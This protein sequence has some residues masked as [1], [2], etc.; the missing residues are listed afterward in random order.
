[1]LSRNPP[2]PRYSPS[3]SSLLRPSSSPPFFLQ[4]Q[5]KSLTP[6]HRVS[7]GPSSPLLKIAKLGKNTLNS[8]TSWLGSHTRLPPSPFFSGAARSRSH[9]RPPPPSP[10]ADRP[11]TSV[12][13]RRRRLLPRGRGA[14]PLLLL[15]AA[16]AEKEEEAAGKEEERRRK[17]RIVVF[18]S[19]VFSLSLF[20]VPTY[21]ART[22]IRGSHIYKHAEAPLLLLLLASWRRPRGLNSAVETALASA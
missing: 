8:A 17:K 9:A 19:P 13:P 2:P 4:V 5:A 10:L 16:A 11:S 3:S 7:T 1:M 14:S 20:Y 12:L 15:A 18:R 22:L 21:K 6:P